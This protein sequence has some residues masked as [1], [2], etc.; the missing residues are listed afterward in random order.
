[1]EK[2]L[3]FVLGIAF[4]ELVTTGL[5]AFLWLSLSGVF[6]LPELTFGQFWLLRQLVQCLAGGGY[7]VK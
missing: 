5:G 7:K 3:T 1:M 6:H 4:I 2:A